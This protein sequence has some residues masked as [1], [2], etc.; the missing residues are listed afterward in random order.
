[1]QGEEPYYI[2]GICDLIEKYALKPE[3]K[4]FNQTVLYGKDANPKEIVMAA[5]RYPMM[6][7]R[8]VILV[9][10]AQN[11]KK[12]LWESFIN[13]LENPLKST[14]LVFAYK[15]K[16]PDQRTKVAKLFQKYV[17]FNSDRLYDNQIPGWI[18]RYI[19]NTKGL[20]IDIAA[21]QM[22]A[23]FLGNDL[24][25]IT[26]EIDKML[27]QLPKEVQIINSKHVEESIGIS[28]DFNV[29]ELQKA[30]SKG[31]FHKSIQ[32]VNYLGANDS[33]KGNMIMVMTS[34]N[35]FFTK[36]LIFSEV[37]NK[38][39]RE[40]ASALGIHEFFL[41]DY[42][43]AANQFSTEKAEHCID[44]IKYYD[45][46]SKGVGATS[47]DSSQLMRELILKIFNQA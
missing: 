2:D 18:E 31:D 27:I 13:Y 22:I 41:N 28:K 24:S 8:Q 39:P 4:S 47:A 17:T 36:L 33:G 43:F 1:L 38:S 20:S 45:L 19:K 25:K 11:I 21:S 23:D 6:A 7:E 34:L 26:N 9:K 29:F 40:Q 42:K 30:L 3:E 5:K 32:I 14:V 46:K 12:D 44:L 10:E 16:K 37:R 35:Q 15:S